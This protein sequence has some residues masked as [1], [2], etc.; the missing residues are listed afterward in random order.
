VG[1]AECNAEVAKFA[2]KAYAWALV[3]APLS[4][5][6]RLLKAGNEPHAPGG[7]AAHTW[8]ESTMIDQARLKL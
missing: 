4:P 1:G 3:P 2:P 7:R 8:M 6:L 5:R